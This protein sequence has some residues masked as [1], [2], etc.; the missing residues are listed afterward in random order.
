MV[1][2]LTRLDGLGDQT[3]Q[4]LYKGFADYDKYQLGNEVTVY[5]WRSI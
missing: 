3:T 5:Q 2:A 4:I 1:A